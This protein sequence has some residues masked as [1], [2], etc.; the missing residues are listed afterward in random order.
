MGLIVTFAGE[1]DVGSRNA[2]REDL[3]ALAEHDVAIADF[4]DVTFVDSACLAELVL[5]ARDRNVRR[6]DP[7]KLVLPRGNV[8]RI[9][10][11]VQVT[12]LFVVFE[13]LSDAIGASRGNFIRRIAKPGGPIETAAI[14]SPFLNP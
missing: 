11:L 2:L 4:T 8:R 7:I 1:Y 14:T 12:D 13:T 10:E 5:L 3:Y 9:V 6:R